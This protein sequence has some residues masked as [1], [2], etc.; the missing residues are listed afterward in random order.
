MKVPIKY[1]GSNQ[2]KEVLEVDENKV[3]DLLATGNY[4]I[5]GDD[6][7]ATIESFKESSKTKKKKLKEEQYIMRKKWLH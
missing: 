5:V 3:A 7:S 4:I 2:P 6:K 1:I